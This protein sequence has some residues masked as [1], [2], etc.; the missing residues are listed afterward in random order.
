[1][2][3]ATHASSGQIYP[4][5]PALNRYANRLCDTPDQSPE[6]VQ[7]AITC[8]LVRQKNHGEIVHPRKY[9]FSILYN[10]HCD[11]LLRQQRSRSE[12]DIDDTEI[13]DT[14]PSQEQRLT[15]LKVIE[16]IEGLPKPQR[17]IL[18]CVIEN[19]M[20]YAEISAA[21]RIPQGTVMS[22]LSRAR[23]ALRVALD[24][25]ADESIAAL[26]HDFE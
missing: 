11:M 25:R 7:E 3:T 8:F 15:Y 17:E 26:F 21:L 9:L 22:R 4:L 12:V 19:D 13:I 14:S 16:K 6:L 1:M 10:L 23:Q 2:T 18:Q 5:M 24:M 20:T